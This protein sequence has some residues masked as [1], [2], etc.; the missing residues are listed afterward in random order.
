MLEM[1][2]FVFVKRLL[3]LAGKVNKLQHA[4]YRPSLGRFLKN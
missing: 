2:I 4:L 3:L 1:K